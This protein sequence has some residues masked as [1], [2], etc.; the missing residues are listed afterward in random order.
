MSKFFHTWTDNK[1]DVHT[2]ELD[3]DHILFQSWD[4]VS[5][6]DAFRGAAYLTSI[7]FGDEKRAEWRPPDRSGR[8]PVEF[9]EQLIE[10]LTKALAALRV[11]QFPEGASDA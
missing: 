10:G 11:R 5:T 8:L 9:A 4:V 2:I 7:E 3:G 6:I 1:G